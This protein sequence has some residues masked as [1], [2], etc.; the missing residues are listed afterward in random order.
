MSVIEYPGKPE[1]IFCQ[2]VPPFV[3]SLMELPR[4]TAITLES[5]SAIE[6]SYKIL[7]PGFAL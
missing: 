1:L 2:V 4:A 3:V 6:A 5:V 7:I